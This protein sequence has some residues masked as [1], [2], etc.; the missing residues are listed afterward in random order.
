MVYDA[1]DECCEPFSFCHVNIF[2]QNIIQ[3]FFCE[4]TYT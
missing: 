1:H 2:F 3:G 4:F